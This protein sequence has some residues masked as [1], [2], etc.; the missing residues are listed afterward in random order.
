L[1]LAA[2]LGIRSGRL[3]AAPFI[4]QIPQRSEAGSRATAAPTTS[5]P[6]VAQTRHLSV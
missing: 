3:N 4:I 2:V 1:N 6:F 5:C